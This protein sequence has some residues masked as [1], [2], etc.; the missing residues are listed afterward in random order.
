MANLYFN[1]K[2]LF[3]K[4]FQGSFI[5]YVLNF[6]DRTFNEFFKYKFYEVTILSW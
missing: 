4:L 5:G 2:K 6:L 3:E 1:Q